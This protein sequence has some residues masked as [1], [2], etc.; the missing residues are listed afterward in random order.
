MKKALSLLLM[1]CLLCSALP[2]CA[3]LT[4]EKQAEA[5]AFFARF[6]ARKN[7]V[8]GAVIVNHGG[9][10]LYAYFHGKAAGGRPV[11]EDTVFKIASVTKMI[12]AIG[13]MQL[14]EAAKLSLDEPLTD[15][16][17]EPLRNPRFPTESITLRQVMSH[18][19]S[20]SHTANYT[21]KP[22]WTPKYFSKNAP[23]ACYEYA[24]LNGGMLGS[25]IEK[26]SGQSLNSY[27]AEHVFSPLEIN[28]AYAATL[29][30]DPSQLA[31]SYDVNGVLEH[32]AS[33][34]LR[35]DAQYD[36]TCKPESHFRASV[37]NLFISLRGM[38]ALGAML[39]SDGVYGGVRLLLPGSVS[40]MRMDQ[41]KLYGSGVTGESPYGLNTYRYLLDGVT[42]YGHQGLWNGRLVDLFYEPESRT[43][44][45]LVMNGSARTVGTVDRAVSAQMESVLQYVAAWLDLDHPDMTII[46]DW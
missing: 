26:A 10:R 4:P 21:G 40:L 45:V 42:W 41:S 2:A 3:A 38:E 44:V 19:S 8:G 27:M 14:V 25:L 34:Y 33:A 20:I 31:H 43:A 12:T 36:D 22:S 46:D 13:V 23:G 35:S 37:G 18:T 32:S 7:T 17:G 11:T 24:N 30:P 39:A 9:E 5:D 16:E 1:L 6:F 29:L 15:A 28:A